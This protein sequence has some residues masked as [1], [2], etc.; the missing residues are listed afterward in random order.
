[1]DKYEE[2]M[3]LTSQAIG[4]LK[5]MSKRSPYDMASDGMARKTARNFTQLA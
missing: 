1:M 3:A 4:I 5:D 2:F